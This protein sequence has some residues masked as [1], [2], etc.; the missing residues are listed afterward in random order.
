MKTFQTRIKSIA[1]VAVASSLTALIASC[2]QWIDPNI[3]TDPNNPTSV[4]ITAQLPAAQ[5]ALAFTN[6]GQISRFSCMLTQQFV[7]TDRQH[8]GYYE[9]IITE[10]DVGGSIWD[11]Y[12]SSVMKSAS[13]MIGQAG[14]SPAYRGAGRILISYSTA[15]LTDTWGNVPYTEI[16]RL[17][18]NGSGTFT[19]KYDD[20]QAIYTALQAQLDTAITELGIA[21]NVTPL[22]FAVGGVPVDAFY[23]GD[24]QKWIRA[25]WTLKARLAI[26]LVKRNGA[27]ASQDALRFLQRGFQSNDD[28]MMFAF[29]SAATTPNP[30]AGF[31]RDRA[32]IDIG[33]MIE[34]MLNSLKD[35]RT[36]A[37]AAVDVGSVSSGNG[38]GFGPLVASNNSSV[39]LLSFAEAKF[40]EA[41]ANQ[42]LGNTDAARTA[43]IAAVN[44]SL[45]ATGVSADDAKA[46]T[47]QTSVVP[48]SGITL[49]RIIE[50]KYIALFAQP[51]VWTDWRRTGFPVLT[52]VSGSAVP[53]RLP[54]PQNERLYNG[55]NI[56][57]GSNQPAWLLGR[58]WWDAN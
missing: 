15:A 11:N 45:A 42:R 52:P 33:P 22:S 13:T 48:A 31:M 20:Q 56:P 54:V 7:G 2:S 4:S 44:A 53:R 46:Y 29:G 28:D 1:L 21:A 57:Q 40:I 6:G 43:F 5:G 38:D 23:S 16:F 39:V 12:Y 25:A 36:P 10:N 8:A 17:Q 24:R 26:H 32:D 58:V 47:D 49:Q 27:A 18:R 9:Y 3:N 34:K 55:A 19:A 41:E 51:E 35:P 14:S 30:L 37:F 50:Q